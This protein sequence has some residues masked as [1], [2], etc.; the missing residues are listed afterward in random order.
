MPSDGAGRGGG[1]RAPARSRIRLWVRPWLRD[2]A[3][4][5]GDDVPA[6][7]GRLASAR[8]CC[9]L[10]LLLLTFTYFSWWP[11][12]RAVV[13]SLQ[14]TNLVDSARWV[15]LDNFRRVLDDP[16]LATAVKNT[17]WFTFLA[18]VFGYPVPIILAVLM[19]EVRRWRGLYAGL[20]YLPVVIPPVAAILLWRVFYDASP[21]GTFNT[22][23]GLGRPRPLPVVPGPDVGDA[24]DRAAR[25]VVGG[26]RHGDH[27]P[28]RPDGSEPRAVRGRRGRRR[29]D[30][31][32]DLARHAA[33]A[34]HRVCS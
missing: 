9:T 24:V 3:P 20:A 2:S 4:P 28:R 27:L 10:P 30:L 13:L 14:E 29:L 33:A 31:A 34:A 16:L 15:G 22:I 8:W 11:L 23:L 32:E 7:G 25:H 18:L 21:T 19:S 5:A 6:A 12:V 17:L 26:R 1:G